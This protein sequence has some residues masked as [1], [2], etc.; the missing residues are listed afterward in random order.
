[1]CRQPAKREKKQTEIPTQREYPAPMD[2]YSITASALSAQRLR[3]DTI[4]SNIANVNTT[5]QADGSVGPYLRRNTVFSPYAS[6][7]TEGA[8]AA[9]RQVNEN[10]APLDNKGMGV[11]VLQIAVDEETPT[12]RVHDPSHPDADE[13]GFV[14]YPNINMVTEMVDM[15]AASRA[16]EASITAFQTTRSMNEATLQM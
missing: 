10:G 3:M 1:M 7:P 11:Q 13:Q 4:A 14:T 9:E 2:I 12:R 6:H 16:Y 8:S 5:R 15:I